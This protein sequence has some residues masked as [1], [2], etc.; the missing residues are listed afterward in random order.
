MTYISADVKGSS[1]NL[2]EV[3]QFRKVKVIVTQMFLKLRVC[4]HR[5]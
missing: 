1:I 2:E 3:E 5:F 4:E